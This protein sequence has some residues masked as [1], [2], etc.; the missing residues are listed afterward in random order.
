MSLFLVKGMPQLSA[1]HA[2]LIENVEQFSSFILLQQVV[3]LCN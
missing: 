2:G 3:L 1:L